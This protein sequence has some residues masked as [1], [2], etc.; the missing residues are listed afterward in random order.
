[1]RDEM[2]QQY[3][4]QIRYIILS[5]IVNENGRWDHEFDLELARLND[6]LVKINGEGEESN[7]EE[8]SFGYLPWDEHPDG[9]FS[10]SELENQ[11]GRFV[12]KSHVEDWFTI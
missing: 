1:M 8:E 7:V 11:F 12:T 10:D 2:I 6:I 9:K 4:E 3:Y 5:I